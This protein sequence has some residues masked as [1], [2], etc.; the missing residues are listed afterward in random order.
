MTRITSQTTNLTA[1]NESFD[2]NLIIRAPT[3]QISHRVSY[4]KREREKMSEKEREGKSEI[5][6]ENERV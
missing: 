3:D 2:L 1:C 4:K 5:E 6:R